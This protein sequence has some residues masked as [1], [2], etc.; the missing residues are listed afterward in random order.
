MPQVARGLEFGLEH[1]FEFGPGRP[2]HEYRK[3]YR[4]EYKPKTNHAGD[5]G[6]A[7]VAE[8]HVAAAGEGSAG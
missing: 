5:G 2:A 3:K 7:C 1:H 8:T 4:Y 6:E